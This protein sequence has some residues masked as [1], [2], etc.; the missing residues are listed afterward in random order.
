MERR[1]HERILDEVY[2]EYIVIDQ[3]AVEGA[4]HEFLD[5][6]TGHFNP[7]NQL[8][9]ISIQ[10]QAILGKIREAY[11]LIGDYLVTIDERIQLLCHAVAQD[12]VGVPIAPN[13]NISL[14]AGGISFTSEDEVAPNTVLE[15][16]IIV[17]PA[18]LHIA[19]LGKVVY[20]RPESPDSNRK[21]KIGVEFTHIHEADR[22][23]LERHITY[24][25]AN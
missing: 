13:E 14:S 10:S 12:Q 21:R 5:S 16:S 7:L 23:A 24:K 1:R 25:Q 18:Y 22:H 9:A 8:Q 20:C 17:I 3:D 6:P 11:P 2:L 15:F 19:A 4:I